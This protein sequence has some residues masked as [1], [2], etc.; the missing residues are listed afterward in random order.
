MAKT[1][2][3]PH[4]R[5]SEKALK[6]NKWWHVLGD[7][8]VEL[9]NYL[10]GWDYASEKLIGIDVSGDLEEL[11]QETGHESSEDLELRIVADC[12]FTQRR[13]VSKTSLRE[14]DGIDDLE[15]TITLP[16]RH[17]AKSVKLSAHLVV[18]RDL[19][20]VPPGVAATRGARLASSTNR[21]LHLEGDGA[22]FPTSAV[23]FSTLWYS[24]V[25][26]TLK[27]NFSSPQDSFMGSVRLWVNTENPVG[28]KLLDVA[29]VKS[30]SPAVKAEIIRILIARLSQQR[31]D[32]QTAISRENSVA[33]VVDNMCNLYLRIGLDES[34]HRFTDDPAE[35]EMTLHREI[36]PLR[37]LVEK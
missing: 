25:P 33:E 32:L 13:F 14:A 8:P 34:I 17:L 5:A 9:P 7:E 35:F 23:P 28:Q 3:Y 4:R 21:T 6:F 36:D 24:D 31:D 16:P 15:A 37:P 11:L 1:R 27:A 12:S 26:W 22:R 29:T 20:H 30:L 2:L 18:A 19:E 10:D